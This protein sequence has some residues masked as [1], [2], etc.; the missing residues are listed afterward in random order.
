MTP[1]VLAKVMAKLGLDKEE[2]LLEVVK[3]EQ[4]REA[5]VAREKEAA[6][7]L[8]MVGHKG[9]EDVK[10]SKGVGGCWVWVPGGDKVIGADGGAGDKGDGGTGATA[11]VK[12]CSQEEFEEEWKSRRARGLLKVESWEELE[13]LLPGAM[14]EEWAQFKEARREAEKASLADKIADT[15]GLE[16]RVGFR[17]LSDEEKKEK[18]DKEVLLMGGWLFEGS[19]YESRVRVVKAVRFRLEILPI[20]RPI[21]SQV[22][23]FGATDIRERVAERKRW[24]ETFKQTAEHKMRKEKGSNYDK[25]GL[26]EWRQDKDMGFLMGIVHS[27]LVRMLQEKSMFKVEAMHV[28]YTGAAMTWRALTSGDGLL[29]PDSVRGVSWELVIMTALMAGHHDLAMMEL[30]SLVQYRLVEGNEGEEWMTVRMLVR[31]AAKKEG[32]KKMLQKVE[33]EYPRGNRVTRLARIAWA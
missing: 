29:N 19:E 10:V 8:R 13:Q 17:G 6:R 20:S 23:Q 12:G 22:D 25:G 15:Y 7:L 14:S 33:N 9:G 24:A 31:E 4:E 16:Q 30:E 32:V 11:G 28:A 2:R 5:K 1:N 26:A 21:K 3:E 27:K 18:I